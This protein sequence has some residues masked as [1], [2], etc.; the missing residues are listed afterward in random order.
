MGVE[1]QSHSGFIKK[2]KSV[3]AQYINQYSNM[4]SILSFFENLFSSNE[5]ITVAENTYIDDSVDEALARPNPFAADP[6]YA[7]SHH[8]VVRI[9]DFMRHDQHLT[10]WL[11]RESQESVLH[12][13]R[14]SLNHIVILHH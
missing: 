2:L 3:D 7:Q 5:P 4:P 6:I 9:V 14:F 8:H 1:K 13:P 12:D 11:L 10:P